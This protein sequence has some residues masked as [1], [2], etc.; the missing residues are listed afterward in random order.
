MQDLESNNWI[1]LD[2][3]GNIYEIQA[4]LIYAVSQAVDQKYLSVY[5]IVLNACSGG[6]LKWT[7]VKMKDQYNE[8]AKTIL[9][10]DAVAKITHLLDVKSYRT[11]RQRQLLGVR[12]LN[13]KKAT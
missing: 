8:L 3:L 13:P 6:T 1:I 7:E 9:L 4:S 11:Q 2:P 12:L 5:K 10:S